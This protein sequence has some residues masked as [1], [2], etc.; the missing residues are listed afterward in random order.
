MTAIER[1]TRE[2]DIARAPKADTLSR[3]RS[4]RV[5]GDRVGPGREADRP[6][7][8]CRS[9]RQPRRVRA[10]EDHRIDRLARHASR[11]GDPIQRPHS[12]VG[13]GRPRCDVRQRRVR[14]AS[15]AGTT[16]AAPAWRGVGRPHVDRLAAAPPAV[17]TDADLLEHALIASR[18]RPPAEAIAILRPA[19]DSIAGLPFEGTSYLWP[20]A[21][22]LTSHLIL[23]ATSAASELAAH[24]LAAGD[25]DGVFEAT[26][27]GLRVLARPRGADRAAHARP[28]RAG[29]HAGVRQEW[30]SYERVINADPWSDG[31]PSPKLVDLRKQLLHP[32]M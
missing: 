9:T 26:G 6:G 28:C 5:A 4:S 23:L 20:D 8:G 21:E 7:R 2:D 30:N 17:V 25:I 15:I 31:E 24:C 22:G 13:T 29:D 11:S 10:I 12:A 27:R 19:V 16:R 14:G 18:A 32:S 3:I 1:S